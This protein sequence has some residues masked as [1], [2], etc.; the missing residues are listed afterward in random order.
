MEKALQVFV[1]LIFQP[2]S[3]LK[4]VPVINISILCLLVVLVFVAYSQIA[5]IHIIVLSTLALGL[6]LSVNWFYYEFQKVKREQEGHEEQAATSAT[7]TTSS[8][9]EISSASSKSNASS[10]KS[11]T[12]KQVD[13][14]QSPISSHQ[15]KKTD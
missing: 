10:S 3:S 15:A 12:W 1:D 11:N 6:L 2:E 4:L 5:V 9:T 7:T 13:S 8:T 14:P